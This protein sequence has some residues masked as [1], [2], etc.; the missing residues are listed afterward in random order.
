M[1]SAEAHNGSDHRAK[2][3]SNPPRFAVANSSWAGTAADET[4][5]LE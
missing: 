3:K 5:K 1:K 2:H 4:G